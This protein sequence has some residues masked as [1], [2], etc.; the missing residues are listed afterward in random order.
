MLLLEQKLHI[1]G[2]REKMFT[3]RQG[4]LVTGVSYDM[5]LVSW[6]YENEKAKATNE[7]VSMHTGA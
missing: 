3:K 4:L 6:P 5:D 7:G 1:K 2:M